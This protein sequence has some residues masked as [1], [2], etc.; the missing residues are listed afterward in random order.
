VFAARLY[1]QLACIRSSLVKYVTSFQ[2][3]VESSHALFSSNLFSS[4]HTSSSAR[5]VLPLQL[6]TYFL[7]SSP[8]TSSSARHVL[9]LQLAMYF[10]AAGVDFEI[11][12]PAHNATNACDVACIVA[13]AQEQFW[14]LPRANF[15]WLSAK[16]SNV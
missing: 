8:R 1:S 11:A 13:T 2:S 14:H 4:P 5:H 10:S 3:D 12:S 9:P 6:A 16:I 15:L 7:F